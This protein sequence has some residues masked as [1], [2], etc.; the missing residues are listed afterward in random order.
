MSRRGWLLFALMSVLWGIPYLMIKVAV[1]GVSVPVL[2]FARTALGALVLVPL[3]ARSGGGLAPVRRHWR[4][5]L[6]FTAVEILGPWALLSDAE[7]RLTSSMTGLL[8]AAVPIIGVVL[9]R[10]TG[11]AERLGPVRW[12]GL[13]VGLAGVGVL[14]GPHLG[15]GSA[16]AIGE[17]MLVAIGYSIAPMIATRRLQDLPSLH[18]AAGSLTIAAVVYAVPAA[19]TWPDAVPRGRVLAALG[20][21]GLVCTALAFMVFFEL[22]REAGTS[23]AMVFTYVNPAVA[24][25][26]GVLLLGE[27][28]T[29]T[30]IASFALILG[31]SV[32]ATVRRAPAAAAASAAE[33]P[34]GG[35]LAAD[36]GV[37]DVPVSEESR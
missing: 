30:I 16:W 26:A 4:P 32:L 27:P 7:H 23:R 31:G 35:A 8:I 36:A 14:A 22:I 21:L 25:V 20:G 28:L 9:A 10:L 5:L 37:A 11:D 34:A 13:L 29:G 15:G 12:A 3:A 1:G 17:V 6:A 18:M 2:V 24:V 19:L 33:P